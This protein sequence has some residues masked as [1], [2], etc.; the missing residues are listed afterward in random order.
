M[1]AAFAGQTAYQ[2]GEG[3]PPLRESGADPVAA[4]GHAAAMALGLFA[5][6]RTGKAQDVE[7]AM[8]V[9]NML[10]NYE[11][12]FDHE[13]KPPRPPVDPRQFGIGA[14]HRLYECASSRGRPSGPPYEN[15]DPRWVMFVADD[16][17]AFARFRDEVGRPD[18]VADEEQLAAVFLTRTARG[19]GGGRR[20]LR[21]RR[22][23]VALRL[24]LRGPPGPGDRDDDPGQP[25]QPRRD[26]LALRPGDRLLRHP[27]PGPAV[28][29]SLGEHTRALL[30]E[31]GYDE[32]T[33]AEL[34]DA[35]VVGLP[36]VPAEV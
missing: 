19:V 24:P 1:I 26:L 16:D 35:G 22:R 30:T 7:S 17:E 28:H 9:S 2:T 4:A 15:P 11:D 32:A 29:A 21:R 13:G 3:N 36:V 23:H 10:L 34:A 20:R 33:I 27:E 8:I 14:T 25:P 5:R 31:V 12:A 6:H 18:L